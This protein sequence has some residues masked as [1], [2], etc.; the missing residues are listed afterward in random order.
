MNKSINFG[1]QPGEGIRALQKWPSREM[2]R[3]IM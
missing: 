2:K 3:R 1:F